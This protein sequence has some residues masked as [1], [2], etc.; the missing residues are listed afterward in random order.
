VNVACCTGCGC[1]VTGAGSGR[2]TSSTA[3]AAGGGSPVSCLAAYIPPAKAAA[4]ST[5][6]AFARVG[7]SSL[8]NASITHAGV[9]AGA[10]GAVTT[11]VLF[12]STGPAAAFGGGAGTGS[13]IR[14]PAIDPGS[15]IGSNFG[16][17]TSIIPD[18]PWG[19]PLRTADS[20]SRLT[21]PFRHS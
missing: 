9:G 12:A 20:A 13:P 14:G 16:F 6:A 18:P 21:D 7:T 1:S 11:S 8:P 2:P 19:E 3:V 10:G 5:T 17:V 4:A 15:A